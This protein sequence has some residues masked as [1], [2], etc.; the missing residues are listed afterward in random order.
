MVIG[1][2]ARLAKAK[3]YF[4]AQ[5]V[6]RDLSW[7]INHD[8]RVGLVGPNGAGKSSI[9]KLLAGEMETSAGLAQIT[10][11]V[12]V[13]YLPQEVHFQL[14]RTVLEEALAAS[15]TLAALELEMHGLEAQMG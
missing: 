13:G 15:P 6:F 8:A 10:R 2:V 14:H 1:T 9:L 12:R 4:G 11:G 3:L 5:E 7:Q